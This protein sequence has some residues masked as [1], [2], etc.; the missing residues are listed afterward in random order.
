MNDRGITLAADYAEL[1]ALEDRA[2]KGLP[3]LNGDMSKNLYRQKELLDEI[4]ILEA[5]ERRARM[6]DR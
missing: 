3:T 2:S 4:A 5:E 1:E 6:H